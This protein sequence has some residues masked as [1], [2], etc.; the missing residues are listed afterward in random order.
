MN[1]IQRHGA[2]FPTSGAGERIVS[3]IGKLQNATQY[4]DTKFDF[5]NDFE[6]DLGTADLIPFG[7]SQCVLTFLRDH[8]IATRL[9]L[10]NS[11]FRSFEAGKEAWERYSKLVKS[12]GDAPFV[13]A[14]SSQ[15]VVDTA[16]NWTAGTSYS[17]CLLL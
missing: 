13:R 17:V 1:L 16:T 6:Y 2:R 15:R 4:L 3:S 8:I 11:V 7:A 10:F 14:S 12:G 9:T 5:L